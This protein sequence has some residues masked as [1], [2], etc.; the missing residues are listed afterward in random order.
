MALG[1][2]NGGP[3]RRAGPILVVMERATRVITSDVRQAPCGIVEPC[4]SF[5][6]ELGFNLLAGIAQ[7]FDRRL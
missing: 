4:G 1:E 2:L 5:Q 7:V 3:F 6:I